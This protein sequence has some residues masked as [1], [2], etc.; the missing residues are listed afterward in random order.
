L[1]GEYLVLADDSGLIVPALGGLPG[2]YSARFAGEGAT[3]EQLRAKLRGMLREKGL[4]RTPAY[5]VSAIALATRW[6]VWTSHGFMYGEVID[7]ER[8]EWGFGYDPM[9]IPKGEEKTL[10]ELPPQ[11]KNLH[12]HRRKGLE[13]LLPLLEVMERSR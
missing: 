2:I 1:N 4:E 11:F 3:S 6:G 12:S 7:G 13:N 9:F 8:G 5:Y 10:G